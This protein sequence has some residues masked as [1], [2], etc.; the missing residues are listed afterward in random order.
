MK[1]DLRALL[2]EQEAVD[3]E[4]L[5][6]RT[7][8]VEGLQFQRHREEIMEAA[9]LL[10]IRGSW[11]SDDGM[12]ELGNW[13]GVEDL[14]LKAA[15]NE[16]LMSLIRGNPEKALLYTLYVRAERDADG[17]HTTE[18]FRGEKYRKYSQ[19]PRQELLYDILRVL[20]YQKS[21]EE[22]LMQGGAHHLQGNAQRIIDQFKA[23]E[24]ALKKRINV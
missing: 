5:D 15:S 21:G 20:G 9:T 17:W 23:D 12:K 8:F 7:E 4:L 14:D 10:L 3:Q 6:R 22:M 24:R 13:L 2:T 19:Q 18:Y 11:W 16:T 1:A